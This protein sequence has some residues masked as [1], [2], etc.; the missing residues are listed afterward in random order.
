[1]SKKINISGGNSMLEMRCIRH[2]I[3]PEDIIKA[4]Q[5]AAY[6]RHYGYKDEVLFRCLVS[7]NKKQETIWL[8]PGYKNAL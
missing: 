8:S 5:P 1:M 4:E 6:P 3:I 7:Y 2:N